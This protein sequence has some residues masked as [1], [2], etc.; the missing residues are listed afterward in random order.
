MRNTY[1][2]FKFASNSVLKVKL[3]PHQGLNICLPLR[4]S[5]SWVAVW[6]FEWMLLLGAA[7]KLT[8]LPRGRTQ[9]CG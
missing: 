5:D 1:V 2:T 3:P 7:A 6:A 9:T 8:Q 4:L